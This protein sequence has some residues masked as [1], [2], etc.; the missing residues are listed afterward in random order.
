M[1]ARV[2]KFISVSGYTSR[3]KAEELIREGRVKV[4]NEIVSLG[5]TCSET[6]EIKIDDVKISFDLKD[7]IY[8]IMNK[9]MGVVCSNDDPHNPSNVF[10]LLSKSDSKSNLFSIGRLDKYT[11]GLIIL[12]N[13]GEFSQKVIHPSSKIKKEYMLLLNKDL[14]DKD[15]NAIENGLVLDGYQ[16]SKCVIN[17]VG[18]KTYTISINEGK[19]RQVRR[20]FE[21]KDYKVINLKRT[22]IGNLELK[23][24]NLEEGQY[25]IVKKTDLDKIFK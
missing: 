18:N 15:K 22:K 13:D 12:T 3:R 25:K 11:T 7:K 19:K 10:D 20:V 6:D 21:I 16:L 9:P 17:E 23:K 14:D 24:F 8:I 1:R 2:Q 5:D 4:N